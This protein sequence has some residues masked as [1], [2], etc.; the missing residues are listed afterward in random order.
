MVFAVISPAVLIL[1]MVSL[2]LYLFDRCE[3]TFCEVFTNLSS[4]KEIGL[5]LL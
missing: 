2:C 3:E 4:G 5:T 1:E